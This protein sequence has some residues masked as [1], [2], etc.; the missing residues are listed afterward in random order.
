[1]KIKNFDEYE[2]ALLEYRTP[3]AKNKKLAQNTEV[4]DAKEPQAEGE[5]V[6]TVGKEVVKLDN[7]KDFEG[8]P[9]TKTPSKGKYS[10]KEPVPEDKKYL[11]DVKHWS[12]NLEDLFDAMKA[13]SPF[14]VQGEAGWG[15]SAVITNLAKKCGY[16]VIILFCDKMLPE[17]LDGLK[18]IKEDS[19]G[20]VY[21][22]NAM[23][24][25][26]QYM[27]DHQET[28]FL[29]FLD[30]L[31]QASNAVLNALMPIVKDHTICGLEFPNYFCG[32]AGNMSYENDLE[33]IPVPLMSRLGGAPITWITGTKEAWEEAFSYLHKEWDSKLGKKLV[34]AF[35]KYAMIF[36]SPRD[37]ELN[38]FNN[39]EG[40]KMSFKDSDEFEEIGRVS[41]GSFAR[42]IKR[43]TLTVEGRQRN[44]GDGN[45]YTPDIQKKVEELAQLCY[46]YVNGSNKQRSFE[47]EEKTEKPT[48]TITDDSINNDRIKKIINLCVEGTDKRFVWPDK[49]RIPVT[50]ETIL[51]LMPN[52]SK[53]MLDFIDSQMKK[54]NL[55]WKYPSYKDAVADKSR[56]SWKTYDW[57]ISDFE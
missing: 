38:I 46:D 42:R 44:M 41:V 51:E 16:S 6:A 28:Q 57:E 14:F 11:T 5:T 54:Q 1:M 12:E 4:I 19:E 47:D 25:W 9:A 13:K 50:H 43:Q 52:M 26:A 35:E 30:E 48:D 55:E 15:K 2:G 10:I 21:Q 53:T 29:L 39:L 32:G 40:Y 33:D 36:A 56:N 20:N 23:P 7:Y 18:A 22:I 34:S 17:D 3:G 49:R 8:K 27:W 24:V 45:K 31:N 37:I